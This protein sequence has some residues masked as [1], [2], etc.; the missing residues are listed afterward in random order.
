MKI[1]APPVLREGS[2]S[3]RMIQRKDARPLQLL[4]QRNRSWLEQWEATHPYSINTTPGTFSLVP[5]INSLREQFKAGSGVPFVMQ[6]DDE[7]VGQLNVNEIGWGALQSAQIGYWI[8]ES[9]A[10][11]NITPTAVAL[12]IDYLFEDL[13]L[14]RVEI[15]IRPENDAS[16]RVITKLGMRFEGRRERYIHIDGDWRD[17]D[18]FALTREEVS[19]RVI[20]RVR[21][22]PRP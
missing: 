6:W 14:H 2:V 17:H 13:R 10:G 8:A 12:V 22:L 7:V 15:C 20:E 11:R 5:A 9:H 4:L 3:V 21:S 16:R 18:C 1:S 19:G